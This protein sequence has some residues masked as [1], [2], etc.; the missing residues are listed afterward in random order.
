MLLIERNNNPEQAIATMTEA[1][2]QGRSLIIFPEGTRNTGD[3]ERL[4]PFKSGIYHLACQ[5]PDIEFVPV[6][7]NNIN[8]V[9]PKGKILPVPLL[10]DVRI[11]QALQKQDN[12]SK[13]AFI[14]RTRQALLALAPEKTQ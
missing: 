5:N 1:L 4:L 10:C 13:Q 12:E 7:I 11:G 2:Q 6:W 9:L 3:D 14:E 8:R